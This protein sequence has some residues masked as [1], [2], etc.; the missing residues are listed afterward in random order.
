MDKK[1][2]KC[3]NKKIHEIDR[4]FFKN[5]N[6][7][8]KKKIDKIIEKDIEV[9]EIINDNDNDTDIDLDL[10]K[11]NKK[12]LEL[13][14]LKLKIKYYKSIE[15]IDQNLKSIQDMKFQKFQLQINSLK[16]EQKKNKLSNIVFYIFLTSLA[17]VLVASL[18]EAIKLQIKIS[19]NNKRK[20]NV[21]PGQHIGGSIYND[22]NI[23]KLKKYNYFNLNNIR[24]KIKQLFTKNNLKKDIKQIKQGLI[25]DLKNLKKKIKNMRIKSLLICITFLIIILGIFKMN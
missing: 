11:L 13:E 5:K 4:F 24:K 18:F 21:P 8:N 6:N 14:K 23:D 20:F 15:N 1:I 19:A 3:I 2:I 7:L 10:S 12:N 9:I 17:N 25:N 16:S 22:D